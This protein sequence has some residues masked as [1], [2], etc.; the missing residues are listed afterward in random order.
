LDTNKLSS[1]GNILGVS[2]SGQLHFYSVQAGTLI[3]ASPISPPYQSSFDVSND[4]ATFLAQY[5]TQQG[6]SVGLFKLVDG[7]AVHLFDPPSNAGPANGV[8]LS[9]DGTLAAAVYANSIR[10]WKVK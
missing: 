6:S 8:A 3:N 4:D 10:I 7:T 1:D 9:A 5:S 2:E